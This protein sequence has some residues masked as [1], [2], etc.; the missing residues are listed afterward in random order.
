MLITNN[1]NIIYS[2]K[3]PSNIEKKDLKINHNLNKVESGDN[4]FLDHVNN[5]KSYMKNNQGATFRN[6]ELKF[7][8]KDNRYVVA[9]EDIPVNIHCF[10]T[11]IIIFFLL[12]RKKLFL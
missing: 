5:L 3:L 9:G 12:S 1:L 11:S 6:L 2:A 8:T 10:K 4:S 7:I